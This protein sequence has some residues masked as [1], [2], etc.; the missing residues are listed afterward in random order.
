ME[1]EKEVEIVIDLNEGRNSWTY[2][3]SDIGYEYVKINTEY[4]T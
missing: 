1:E 2:Y 4:R 3:S